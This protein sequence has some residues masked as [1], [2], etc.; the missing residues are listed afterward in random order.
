M[1]RRITKIIKANKKPAAIIAI[2]VIAV[3]GFIYMY[4]FS[5]DT[6]MY[7]FE[8]SE[9][10]VELSGIQITGWENGKKSWEVFAKKADSNR[11]QEISNFE[12]V[13]NG[14]V[15]KDS[16]TVVEDL[17]A[18]KVTATS[19]NERIEAFGKDKKN[20][21]QALVDMSEAMSNEAN[22]KNK[23]DMTFFKA[24]HFIY[25]STIKTTSADNVSIINKRYTATSSSMEVDHQRNLAIMTNSPVIHAG[26]YAITALTIESYYK[27][28]MLKATDHVLLKIN[29]KDM[30]SSVKSDTLFFST[31]DYTAQMAGH[32]IFAQKGKKVFS[33]NM[34]YDDKTRDALLTGNVVAIL[35]RAESMLKK[36]TL[37][38]IKGQETKK[39]LKE[40]TVL[41]CTGLA[42][43]TKNGN[44]QAEGNVEVKQK[45]K[46]AK[47]DSASYDEENEIITMYGNV[48]IQRGDEWIKTDKIII[49]IKDQTFEAIGGVESL[50]KFKRR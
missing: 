30:R 11:N 8:R 32:V 39:M 36:A 48:F 3:L 5:P 16:K 14:R 6:Q 45:D 40:S 9:K 17:T 38:K 26:T 27:D 4:F 37:E 25:D 29:K 28:N 44:A 43:S 23:R 13:S 24:Q 18:G 12:D 42:I 10:I 22:D 49:S 46:T 19:Y 1:P 41:S 33:D 34:S 2:S 31:K 15:Y 35:S 47:A 50:F 20:P 7:K 21:I